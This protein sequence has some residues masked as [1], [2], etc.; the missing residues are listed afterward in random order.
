[1]DFKFNK[2]TKNISFEEN[3]TLNSFTIPNKITFLLIFK[4]K[5]TT[6]FVTLQT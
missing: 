5:T 3:N 2:F 6:F 4:L 1:M